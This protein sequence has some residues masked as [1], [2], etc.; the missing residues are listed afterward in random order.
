[1]AIHQA[2]RRELL[3]GSGACPGPLRRT[4][5]PKAAILVLTIATR[6]LDGLVAGAGRDPD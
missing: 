5:A 6:R 4:G 1:M 2:T 3:A